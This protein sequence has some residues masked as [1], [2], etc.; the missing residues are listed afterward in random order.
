MLEIKR[1]YE[2][3][4]KALRWIWVVALCAVSIAVVIAVR[5]PASKQPVQIE[6]GPMKR[7]FRIGTGKPPTAKADLEARAW[8]VLR[9]QLSS[10]YSPQKP[11]WDTKDWYTKCKVGLMQC[12]GGSESFL[13][14]APSHLFD[15]DQEHAAAVDTLSLLSGGM[16][17]PLQDVIVHRGPLFATEPAQLASVVF[18]EKAR[19]S[20]QSTV[21]AW[22]QG[23]LSKVKMDSGSILAK[24]IWNRVPMSNDGV[25]LPGAQVLIYPHNSSPAGGAG[26]GTL[27]PEL[28]LN[29]F[30]Q[31]KLDERAPSDSSACANPVDAISPLCFHAYPLK[32]DSKLIQQAVFGI[33]ATSKVLF[34]FCDSSPCYFVL[35][36]IH[37]MVR[38]DP[39]D[40]LY[41][42]DTPWLFITFWW[43]G[44]DN[45]V[46]GDAPWKYYQMNVTQLGRNDNA[47]V[48]ESL[49]NICFNPYLEGPNP[50]GAVSNCVSCH[51]FAEVVPDKKA[52]SLVSVGS[53]ECL[54]T[55]PI[56]FAGTDSSGARCITE[57]AYKKLGVRSDLV[58][59]VARLNK[60]E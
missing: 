5:V 52:V 40:P 30:Q 11:S 10:P 17:V 51:R 39:S 31:V 45:K 33:D 34:S 60:D 19:K 13:T 46:L 20:L 57:K 14:N 23:D 3:I 41:R 29:D 48:P 54:G 56:G 35:D 1:G 2:K 38:L 25:S 58:W 12:D 4:M 50:N 18:N 47:G 8:Q 44:Q 36:G 9:E 7:L 43:T 42:D 53:G 16:R 28:T 27:Q 22:N 6:P 55:R 26:G 59:S 21:D 24:A 37:L 15:T 32:A 49:R